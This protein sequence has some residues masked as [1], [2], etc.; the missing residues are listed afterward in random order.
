M[1][2][3]SKQRSRAS[4]GHEDFLRQQARHGQQGWW[5]PVDGGEGCGQ[6]ECMLQ[7]NGP[8]ASQLRPH[9]P[10]GNVGPVLAN[11][12][13]FFKRSRKDKIIHEM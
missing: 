6:L 3:T 5:R 9:L 2:L 11:L 7:S 12:L 1:N 10:S 4:R 13:I 8:A